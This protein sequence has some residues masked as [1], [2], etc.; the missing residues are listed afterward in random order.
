MEF[1]LLHYVADRTLASWRSK[2]FC[3]TIAA[4]RHR[5]VA[6]FSKTTATP[7][8]NGRGHRIAKRRRSGV[9]RSAAAMPSGYRGRVA[10]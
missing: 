6:R 2:V 10:E 7:I 3:S 1:K 8:P 9:T 5:E 4:G